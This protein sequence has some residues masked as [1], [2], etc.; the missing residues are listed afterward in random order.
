[1]ANQTYRVLELI[2]R[3]NNNEKV[4]IAQLKNE[5][6]WEGKSDKTVPRDLDI[7]K[8]VFPETL[9]LIKGE[10]GCYKAALEQS[11][12]FTIEMAE[13]SLERVRTGHQTRSFA[14]A[15]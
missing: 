7:I 11:V 13:P 4:C 5:T 15:K 14:Y 8:A 9:H 2:R 3:F 10:Q 6:M 1:M 12:P